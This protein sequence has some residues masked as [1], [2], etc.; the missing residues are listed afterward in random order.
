MQ[1]RLYKSGRGTATARIIAVTAILILSQGLSSFDVIR[2]RSVTFKAS[3]GLVITADIYMNSAE[4]PYIILLHEQNSS[5]GE[6]GNIAPRLCKMDYNC[7]AVDLRN[8]GFANNISNETVKRCREQKCATDFSDVEK[9][10]L[11]SVQYAHELSGKPVILL[12]SCANASLSLKLAKSSE[13]VR[14]VVA[15]SP[16]EYFQPV[17]TIRD[18][19]SGLSK[20]VFIASSEPEFP[21]MEELASNIDEAYKTLFKPEL[22]QGLRG[23]AALGPKNQHNSEYWLALLLFFKDLI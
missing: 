18:T 17:L 22:G 9:D 10:I 5:R 2:K 16:G 12:G 3:D 11:A 19:I 23:T 4:N 14:A 7:L 20:P 8:G 1:K 13:L 15:F 21:Y 6:F